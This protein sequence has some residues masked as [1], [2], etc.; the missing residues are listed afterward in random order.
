[1][2]NATTKLSI[3]GFVI[4]ALLIVGVNIAVYQNTNTYEITVTDK[5]TKKDGETSKYLIF[6]E[7]DGESKVFK[8]TDALFAGKFNSSDL[9][10]ELKVGERYEVKTIGFR[11]PILSSYE[12]IV[13]VSE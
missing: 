8:N 1:M 4:L 2:R 13:E 7:V 6:A 9:Q 12:N 11:I 5:E 3:I 10:G